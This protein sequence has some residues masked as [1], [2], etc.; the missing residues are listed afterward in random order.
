MGRA[1]RQF[2]RLFRS[3]RAASSSAC[4]IPP[5]EREIARYDL[6]E[7]TDEV[8]HGYLPDAAPG[9]DLRLSRLR[10][11]RP[12]RRPSLQSR[13][14]AARSLCP[15]HCRR[16]ALVRCALRL[17]R[18][19][20]RAPISRS[21]GATAPGAMPKGVVVDRSISP[22]A[23]TRRQHAPWSETVIYEAHVRGPDQARHR[24][25]APPAQRGTF[26]ALGHPAVIDASAPARHH[27]A[28]SC[29]R[30]T[31]SCRTARCCDRGLTQLLGL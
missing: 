12:G 17:S 2:R 26:A 11:L 21:I 15:G 14:A 13:Q 5:D 3:R 30:C 18:R 22:G 6:P 9:L 20:R 8:W 10:P 27:R 7:Y 16:I 24:R 31:P 4:S 28:S 19:T 25:Y 1:R 29:C 23:T